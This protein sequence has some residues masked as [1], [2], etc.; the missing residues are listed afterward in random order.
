MPEQP[1]DSRPGDPRVNAALADYLQ[2]IDRGEQVAVEQFLAGH[3]DIANELRS[4]LITS[5]ELA[6][7]RPA[8]SPAPPP[9]PEASTHSVAEQNVETVA[10]KR[11]QDA[12]AKETFLQR[13]PD[14]FGRYRIIRPLGSGAMG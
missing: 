14:K 1:R 7:L 6:Q 9:V 2:R 5:D 13:L 3:A 4:L 10:P 12:A 8:D 11:V